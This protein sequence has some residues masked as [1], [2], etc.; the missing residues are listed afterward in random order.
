MVRSEAI[1]SFFGSANI[2]WFD[3]EF[4][5][6]RYRGTEL[7]YDNHYLHALIAPR[8]VAYRSEDHSTNP[9]GAYCESGHAHLPEDYT[10][11]LDLMG[12]H[13]HEWWLQRDFQRKLPPNLD[14]ILGNS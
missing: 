14:V 10:V 9:V 1:D 8:S 6:H 3:R 12:L 13:L 11:R 5:A 2:F 4:V 7:P